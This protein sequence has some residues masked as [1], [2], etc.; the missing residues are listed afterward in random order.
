MNKI[1]FENHSIQRKIKPKE[2]SNRF[3]LE[4]LSCE[5]Y[6]LQ[7]VITSWF[8]IKILSSITR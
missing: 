5:F 6:Q 1:N 2:I 4:I 8:G 7:L 3:E